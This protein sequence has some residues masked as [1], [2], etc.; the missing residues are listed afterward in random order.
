[1]VALFVQTLLLM[2]VAYFVGAALACVVRR[3]FHREARPVPV[4]ER[5][6]DPLP[7][8][9]QAGAVRL[10]RS[11]DD[12]GS[13]PKPVAPRGPIT[14][15]SDRPAPTPITVP[16]GVP[17]PITVVAEEAAAQDLKRIR[18]IDAGIES[19][20][21]RLGVRRYEE[22]ANWQ[23]PDVE[24][25]GKALGLE[26]RINQENWIEQAQVLAKGA[27]THYAARLARGEAAKGEPTPDEGEP[28]PIASAVTIPQVAIAHRASTG[29]ASGVAAEI[30][31]TAV[32][33]GMRPTMLVAEPTTPDVSDRAAFAVRRVE[34]PAPALQVIASAPMQTKTEPA[35]VPPMAPA[36][37]IRPAAPATRDNLQRIGGIDGEIE[38]LLAAQGVIRYSQI[39]HW[40][41]ADV[42]RF[43]TQLGGAN[44]R[45]GRENWIEQAQ[46]LSRGG[47]TAF[48]RDYD[49]RTG[50]ESAVSAPRPAKLADAIREN[51]AKGGE[52]PRQP[53]T[54]LGVLRSVRSQAYQNA[55]PGPEAAQRISYQSKVGRSAQLDDLKRIRGIGVLIEKKLNSMGVVAYEQIANWTAEEI[56]RVSQSLDFKGR[57]ERENWVEQARILASGGATEFSRRVDRGEVETSRYRP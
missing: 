43:D 30:A 14:V 38:K 48:S 34:E 51:S 37:S 55:D 8:V 11:T 12:T 33:E 31:V 24:R 45:I 23:R 20:L 2:A 54:D 47:D 7:E 16:S 4:G 27:E 25:I 3:S 15:P 52:A 42:A 44:G 57:I 35:G 29:G 46:I 13:A 41:P 28:R 6:V 19:G 26:G 32:A 40:S 10:G 1:M 50:G 36:V 9:V 22:I 53:R 39:A 5:R 18:R 49:R 56:G 17:A 21:N